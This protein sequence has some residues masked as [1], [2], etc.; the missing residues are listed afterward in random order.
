MTG[1]RSSPLYTAISMHLAETS[2]VADLI[3]LAPLDQRRPVLL[4]AAVHDLLLEGLEHDLASCYP[5]LGGTADLERAPIEFVH[6]CRAHGDELAPLLMQRSTQTN[7]VGRCAAL[8]PAFAAISAAAA[9][10]PLALVEVGASAGLNLRFDHYAVD[11][12]PFGSVGPAASEV[13]LECT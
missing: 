11:Y 6:F 1:A 3:E 9:G 2:D 5:T 7:E 4:F 10:R 13:R 8:L 12:P